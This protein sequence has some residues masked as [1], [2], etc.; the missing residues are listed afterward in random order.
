M[1]FSG[2]GFSDAAIA[3][4]LAEVLTV[5]TVVFLY[6]FLQLHYTLQYSNTKFYHD[7]ICPPSK[8]ET[9]PTE[10]LQR[11]C[12]LVAASNPYPLPT[13]VYWPQN[14]SDMQS[15]SPLADAEKVAKSFPQV[16]TVEFQFISDCLLL[17]F[18]LHIIFC[19]SLVFLCPL[20]AQS[21]Y[22]NSKQSTMR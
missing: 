20:Y 5:C 6:D 9:Q 10:V 18:I 11:H 2:G 12:I 1:Q 19:C 16:L 14:K 22:Q 3:E 15:E 4:G 7:Q 21:S 17:I 13:P 8:T